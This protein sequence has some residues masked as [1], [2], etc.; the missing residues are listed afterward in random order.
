MVLSYVATC[1]YQSTVA[2]GRDQINKQ[3]E[4]GTRLLLIPIENNSKWNTWRSCF[5][6][7]SNHQ[8][9]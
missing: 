6:R 9:M 7:N 2:H 1:T 8:P 5:Y 3:T 4:G